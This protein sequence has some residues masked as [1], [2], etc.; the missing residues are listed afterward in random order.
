MKV[1][2]N[3]GAKGK[4]RASGNVKYTYWYENCEIHSN[5]SQCTKRTAKTTIKFSRDTSKNGIQG[6]K[7]LQTEETLHS[8]R[9]ISKRIA[10]QFSDS[11]PMIYF[12]FRQ[13]FKKTEGN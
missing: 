2:Q 6:G 12:F 10:A 9:I 11:F 13:I 3:N 8:K 1:I 5:F 7:F 4:F